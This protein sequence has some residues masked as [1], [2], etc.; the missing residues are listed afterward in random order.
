MLLQVSSI[1][2]V[3]RN[4]A[5]TSQKNEFN[6]YMDKFGL[7]NGQGWPRPNPWYANPVPTMHP[8]GY[9][10]QFTQP[11]VPSPTVPT[12]SPH[13]DKKGRLTQ[14]F[15]HFDPFY[16]DVL[17]RCDGLRWKPLLTCNYHLVASGVAL[18]ICR[19]VITAGRPCQKLIIAHAA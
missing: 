9:N 6:P 14:V 17:L 11:S 16:G 13:S 1:N 2:R 8:L 15:S 10:P 18:V 5:S 4:L 3:L 12:A 7:L 19:V